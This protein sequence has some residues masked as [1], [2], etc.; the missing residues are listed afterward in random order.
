MSK[1]AIIETALVSKNKII[2]AHVRNAI[3][4]QKYLNKQENIECDL[5]ASNW[6]VPKNKYDLILFSYASFYFDFKVFE[7]LMNINKETK[8]GWI[9]NEYNLSPNTFFFTGANSWLKRK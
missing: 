2:D 7:E 3:E 9:T 1:I 5:L 6:P 8:V 4:L